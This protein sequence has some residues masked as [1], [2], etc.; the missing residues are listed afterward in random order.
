MS[1]KGFSWKNG[2]AIIPDK[3]KPDLSGTEKE[4]WEA[5]TREERDKM[6][7]AFSEQV[8]E[9]VIN[10]EIRQT[11]VD[12]YST[13]DDHLMEITGRAKDQNGKTYYISKNSWGADGHIYSGFCYASEACMRCKVINVMENRNVIPSKTSGLLNL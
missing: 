1:E 10:Q 13:S 12:D 6:L 8:K 2:I 3:T 7:F 4:R 11:D 9:K 5:L